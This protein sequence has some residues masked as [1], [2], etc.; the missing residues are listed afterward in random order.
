MHPPREVTNCFCQCDPRFQR[1]KFFRSQR[2]IIHSFSWNF[3]TV[4]IHF[5]PHDF[6]RPLAST[7]V[8]H[9]HC[10]VIV[11]RN[12]ASQPIRNTFPAFLFKAHDNVLNRAVTIFLLVRQQLERI[13][14]V[15]AKSLHDHVRPKNLHF[16]FDCAELHHQ[17][18]VGCSPF[19]S[20]STTP[21]TAV[22]LRRR[23]PPNVVLQRKTVAMRADV[24]QGNS[25][26]GAM[27]RR[28]SVRFSQYFPYNTQTSSFLFYHLLVSFTY[29]SQGVQMSSLLPC[30][31]L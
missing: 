20:F 25:S 4:S 14:Q 10:T 18:P 1:V 21:P 13:D 7:L 8:T 16:I 23:Y 24:R 3:R 15:F 28:K 17:N 12:K 29:C 9:L 27:I 30:I 22:L 6:E 31:F 19:I 11:R 2:Q 5:R 26:P